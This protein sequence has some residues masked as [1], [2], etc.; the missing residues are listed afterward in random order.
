MEKDHLKIKIVAAILLYNA[1]KLLNMM[2]ICVTDN[3]KLKI[4]FQIGAVCEKF[5]FDLKKLLL[6]DQ[7]ALSTIILDTKFESQA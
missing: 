3:N 4:I 2:E 7:A 1:C 5:S 6:Q